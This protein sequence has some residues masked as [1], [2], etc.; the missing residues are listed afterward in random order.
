MF[1]VGDKVKVLV[2][3]YSYTDKAGKIRNYQG[4]VGKVMPNAVNSTY[5]YVAVDNALS[6]HFPFSEKEL[7]LVEKI[8]VRDNVRIVNSGPPYDFYNGRLGK[9]TMTDKK[10][11]S[12]WD[13]NVR[14]A[15][16]ESEKAFSSSEVE[17]VKEESK[18]FNLGDK[19]RVTIP[20]RFFGKEGL[21]LGADE[22]EKFPY[23]VSIP[24]FPQAVTSWKAEELE[25]I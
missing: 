25:L 23:L 14:L 2:N 20:G 6:S 8:K 10:G 5:F 21:V 13:L 1:K 7:E 9:V 19:V 15:G 11:L 4:C 22:K 17:I 12:G 3:N 18:K 24:S 16:D